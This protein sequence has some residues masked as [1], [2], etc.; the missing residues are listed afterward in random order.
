[1]KFSNWIKWSNR[2]KLND[3]QYPGVYVISKNEDDIDNNSF[4][5]IREIIYIGMTN[6]KRG[7]KRRLRQFDNTIFG[8]EGHGGAKRVRYKYKDYG[9]LIKCLY[10]AICSFKCDVNSNKEKDLLIMGKVTEYEYI[11]LSEYVKR[12][13]MLPEFNNKKLSPKK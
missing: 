12:F 5:W 9:K 11:C 10:V 8:K 1:M 7:L 4:T 2:N 13:S 6:S 3:L